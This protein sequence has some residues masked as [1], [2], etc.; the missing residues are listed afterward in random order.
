MIN[1]PVGI[2]LINHRPMF[3]PIANTQIKLSIC[4][5]TGS[6][7]L[8]LSYPHAEIKTSCAF[9]YIY[10][11]FLLVVDISKFI[12]VETWRRIFLPRAI[13]LPWT[14]ST[15]ETHIYEK[16]PYF[17]ITT[18]EKSLKKGDF[19]PSSII[20]SFPIVNV[21]VHILNMCIHN[22]SSKCA[23]ANIKRVHA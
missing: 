16:C 21:P 4:R 12:T 1:G 3:R 18:S 19:N 10:I 22:K 23:G 2:I 15:M 11:T 17:F 13:Y 8:L 7:C 14:S 9:M 5:Q 20:S 6:S